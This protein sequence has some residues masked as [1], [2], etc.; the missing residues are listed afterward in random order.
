M[1]K[2]DYA[3]QKFATFQDLYCV[4]IRADETPG[5]PLIAVWIDTKM[6]AFNTVEKGSACVAMDGGATEEA[7]AFDS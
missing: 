4:W 6:R 7:T 1:Y 3:S 2:S 5:A